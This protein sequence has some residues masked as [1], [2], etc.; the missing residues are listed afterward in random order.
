MPY[1]HWFVEIKRLGGYQPSIFHGDRPSE[2]RAGGPAHKFRLPPRRINKGMMRLDMAQL[3]EVYS[4]DGR[5]YCA[6]KP[7]ELEPSGGGLTS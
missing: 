3:V 4:P 7:E 5:F 1:D 6:P 2:K